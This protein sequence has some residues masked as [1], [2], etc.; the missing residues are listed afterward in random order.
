MVG[1]TDYSA[2]LRVESGALF[3]GSGSIRPMLL[4]TTRMVA[5]R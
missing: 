3:L 2:W 4:T 5:M 1:P